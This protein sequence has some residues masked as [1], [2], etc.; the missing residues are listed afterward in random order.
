[1]TSHLEVEFVRVCLMDGSAL[2]DGCASLPLSRRPHDIAAVSDN[3]EISGSLELGLMEAQ[4]KQPQTWMT[5]H[6][7]GY[8]EL[9]Q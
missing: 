8:L 6:V 9:I 2:M 5:L 4:S 7:N 1:V 3:I